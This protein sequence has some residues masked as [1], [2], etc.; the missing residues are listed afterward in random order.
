MQT[1]G[2][3]TNGS[4]LV[5][6]D[7]DEIACFHAL[8]Q[9]NSQWFYDLLF[10]QLWPLLFFPECLYRLIVINCLIDNAIL[11]T[12]NFKDIQGSPIL[13]KVLLILH[14]LPFNLYSISLAIVATTMLLQEKSVRS[15]LTQ[16]D[17]CTHFIYTGYLSTINHQEPQNDLNVWT[18]LKSII[19]SERLL[20]HGTNYQHIPLFLNH[21]VYL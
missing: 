5:G 16:K 8:C 14:N 15:P 3:N 9:Y 6:M 11:C 10:L 7:A 21:P 12:R 1:D 13:G 17:F 19:V 18:A 4:P 20:Y 2:I